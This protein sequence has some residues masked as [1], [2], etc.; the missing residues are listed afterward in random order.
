MKKVMT[1]IDLKEHKNILISVETI[2]NIS[3]SHKT[4]NCYVNFHFQWVP[5]DYD[6]SSFENLKNKS[7]LLIDGLKFRKIY[8][9]KFGRYGSDTEILNFLKDIINE[10]CNKK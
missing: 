3:D 10:K 1:I 9:Q 6:F 8:F 7:Y 4:Y 2:V 5:H